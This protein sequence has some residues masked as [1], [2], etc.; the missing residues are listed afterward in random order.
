VKL[1]M[2]ALQYLRLVRVSDFIKYNILV[3]LER[4]WLLPHNGYIIGLTSRKRIIEAYNHNTFSYVTG[5]E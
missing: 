5:N 2:I 1:E 4:Q 3:I